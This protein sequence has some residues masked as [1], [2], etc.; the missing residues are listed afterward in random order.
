MNS[1]LCGIR[2][3]Q[4]QKQRTDWWMPEAEGRGNE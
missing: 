3:K 4:T 1:L 2:K